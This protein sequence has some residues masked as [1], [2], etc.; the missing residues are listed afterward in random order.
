MFSISIY[1]GMKQSPGMSLPSGEDRVWHTDSCFRNETGTGR[2][3]YFTTVQNP[4]VLNR[5]LKNV[6]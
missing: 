5:L 4:L 1:Q 2:H 6:L 3:F